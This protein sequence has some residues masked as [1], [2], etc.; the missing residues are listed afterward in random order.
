MF[1]EST[2][3]LTKKLFDSDEIINHIVKFT[4]AG[5]RAYIKENNNDK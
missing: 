5:I 2:D 1:E 4:C 3:D